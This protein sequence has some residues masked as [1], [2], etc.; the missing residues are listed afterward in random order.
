M[1]IAAVEAIPITVPLERPVRM[2]HVTLTST[3]NVLV[4][5]ESED[6]QVGW[7]EGVEAIDVT[8]DNQDRIMASIR[9]MAPSLIGED[10]WRRTAIWAG[11]R[12][13]FH[14]NSTAIG[15]IDVA[16]HD[17]V[18]RALGVPV[19]DLIGGPVRTVVPALIL[20]GNGDTNTDMAAF[21]TRYEEGY[22]WFKLKLGIGSMED[23]AETLRRMVGFADDTV[24]CGDA[25]GAWTEPESARF[26]RSMADVPV[27]FIEQPT[28]R[29]DA[30]IRLALQS[31]VALCA[32]EGTRSL[33]DLPALAGTRIAGVSLKLIKHGG[34]TGL[35]RAAAFCDTVGLS[36]NL[37]GKVAETSVAAAAN[38]HCAAAMTDTYFGCSPANQTVAADVTHRSMRPVEGSIEVPT[39]PG[40]GIQVDEDLVRSLSS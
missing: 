38:V 16:L 27:R 35:M 40:L 3:Q 37:A 12:A 36:I 34:I 29:H 1:R 25:N 31:P 8:G 21:E 23:E 20:L 4:R 10:P 19:V 24:L 18:G 32:D 22:R 33:D 17:L 26:L 6:G 13:R 15:A 39:A 30:M 11:L 2:S 7:G 28:L 5:I 9:A 14:A